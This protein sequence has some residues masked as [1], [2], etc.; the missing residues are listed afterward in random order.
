MATKTGSLRQNMIFTVSVSKPEQHD[1]EMSW[2]SETLRANIYS[3]DLVAINLQE[4]GE[5]LQNKS[6]NL[7]SGL[8]CVKLHYMS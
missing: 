5:F 3:G 8:E 6:L 2:F 1:P 4:V 7:I